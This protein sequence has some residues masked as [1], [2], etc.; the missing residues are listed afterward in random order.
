MR[1]YVILLV[2]SRIP[3]KDKAE[4][5][6]LLAEWYRHFGKVAPRRRYLDDDESGS[7]T[8]GAKPPWENH[9]LFM[10]LPI[11]APSDLAFILAADERTMDEAENRVN[12]ACPELKMQLQ[13][14]LKQKYDYQYQRKMTLQP[15]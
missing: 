3:S 2:M 4:L 11:G 1:N 7:G 15:Y 12:E 9:P 14:T 5:G 13:N 8:G 6:E 10:D